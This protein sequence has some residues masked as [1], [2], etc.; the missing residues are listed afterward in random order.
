MSTNRVTY[1]TLVGA[2]VFVWGSSGAC[3]SQTRVRLMQPGVTGLLVNW[4]FSYTWKI[5]GKK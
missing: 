1:V 3:L 4:Q 2:L 5:Q